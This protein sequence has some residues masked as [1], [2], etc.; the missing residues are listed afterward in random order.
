MRDAE[1]DIA[2]ALSSE[3]WLTVLDG[4]L[5]GIRHRRGLPVIGYVK[6]HHRRMLTREHWVRVPE[7]TAGERS[8]LSRG[9]GA[10]GWLAAG[11]GVGSAPGRTGRGEPDADRGPRTAS[12]PAARGRTP[13]PARGAGGGARKQPRRTDGMIADRRPTGSPRPS[14]TSHPRAVRAR[15]PAPA[16][17]AGGRPGGAAPGSTPGRALRRGIFVERHL[18][19]RYGCQPLRW[20]GITPPDALNG[21]HRSGRSWPRPSKLSPRRP[22]GAAWPTSS[23]AGGAPRARRAR[24][25]RGAPFSGRRRA[26]EQVLLFRGDDRNHVPAPEQ[27]SRK[28]PDSRSGRQ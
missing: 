21:A 19:E 13:R 2:E 15:Q 5:H 27:R 20:S 18:V 7:L 9:G 6:T 17:L 23:S 28:P 3:G 25:A 14:A 24:D 12:A 16:A 11:L 4:S 1:A 8:G 22:T 26:I 10:S